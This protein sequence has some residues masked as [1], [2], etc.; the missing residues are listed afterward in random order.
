MRTR[1]KYVYRLP[2]RRQKKI[3]GCVSELVLGARRMRAQVGNEVARNQ[4][5][6]RQPSTSPLCIGQSHHS[7]VHI[8]SLASCS[9][10]RTVRGPATFLR[11]VVSTRTPRLLP[12]F[13][14][15]NYYPPPS[16]LR[17]GIYRSGV[18]RQV[19]S[20]SLTKHLHTDL[21]IATLD[22]MKIVDTGKQ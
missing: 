4:L 13:F 1:R 20:S 12:R 2:Y 3:E 7:F 22:T 19:Q 8:P 16:K 21:Y 15:P 17:Q 11:S 10:P 18:S 14:R 5:A 9:S 6:S